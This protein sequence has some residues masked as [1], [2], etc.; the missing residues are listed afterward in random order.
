MRVL[1][2]E[3]QQAPNKNTVRSGVMLSAIR[4]HVEMGPGTSQWDV[5]PHFVAGFALHRRYAATFG[6]RLIIDFL[7]SCRL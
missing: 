1:S 7:F 5:F 3:A 2:S 4:I 6:A